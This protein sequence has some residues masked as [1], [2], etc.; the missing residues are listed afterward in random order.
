MKNLKL[1]NLDH[2]KMN[3]ALEKFSAAKKRVVQD[4]KSYL[5]QMKPGA[6]KISYDMPYVDIDLDFTEG[7]DECRIECA[8]DLE[9]EISLSLTLVVNDE[10]IFNCPPE[11]FNLKYKSYKL[12]NFA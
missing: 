11:E 10:T 8:F 3:E 6:W 12:G 1:K 5:N 9:E 2:L 4:I 7:Y